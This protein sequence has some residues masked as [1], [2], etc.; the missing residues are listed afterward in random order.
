MLYTLTFN[1]MRKEVE[2]YGEIKGDNVRLISPP[3]D[4]TAHWALDSRPDRGRPAR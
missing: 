1:G 3:M 2:V 4:P